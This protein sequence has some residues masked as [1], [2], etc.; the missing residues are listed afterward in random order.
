MPPVQYTLDERYPTS[1]EA[2]AIYTGYTAFVLSGSLYLLSSF[3]VVPLRMNA[4]RLS[5]LVILRYAS[6]SLDASLASLI[7]VSTEQL[8]VLFSG[9][10]MRFNDFAEATATE[11]M[12]ANNNNRISTQ[13]KDASESHMNYFR[14]MK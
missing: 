13:Q 1:T 4:F 5:T 7:C 12:S 11:P 2:E 8:Y 6:A 10:S 3:G 14:G 9:V